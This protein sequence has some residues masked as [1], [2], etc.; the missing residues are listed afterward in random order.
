MACPLERQFIA[1]NF[2]DGQL[3]A[4]DPCWSLH[5]LPLHA[6]AYEVNA[7]IERVILEQEL[8]VSSLKVSRARVDHQ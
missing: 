5:R 6:F 1:T 2:P 7:S 4:D 3:S 8:S